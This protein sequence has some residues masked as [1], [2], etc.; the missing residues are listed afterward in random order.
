[1]ADFDA[2]VENSRKFPPG[3]VRS[4]KSYDNEIGRREKEVSKSTSKHI[5]KQSQAREP[6]QKLNYIS[7]GTYEP[8]ESNKAE[9][10]NVHDGVLD[11]EDGIDVLS[12]TMIEHSCIA[13]EIVKDIALKAPKH[14]EE[15]RFIASL[16]LIFYGGSWTN[17]AGII[18]AFEAFGTK[19]VL[20]EAYKVGKSFCFDDFDEDEVTPSQIKESFRKLGLQSALLIA[21]LVSP[22][23]AEICITVAFASK[24]TPLVPVEELLKQ[25]MLS[26]DAVAPEFDDYFSSIDT[27]WFDLIA[28][29]A[30]NILSLIL[31]G[32]FPRMTTAMYMGYLGVTL[33]MEGLGNRQINIPIVWESEIFDKSYWMKKST[34]YYA[35]G[36]VG[37]MAVWQAFTDYNGVC[38][39]LSWSMFLFPVVKVYN[40][41]ATNAGYEDVK[42]D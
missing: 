19:Q 40:L 10:E 11:F 16:G 33:F 26:P 25:S 36:I 8:T 3:D 41:L 28:V 29:I 13:F 32:C 15:F 17:L 1:M 42:T 18:A 20:E 5:F 9:V 35:W 22:S 37:V 39:I 34:Q 12:R 27:S 23:W 21:V 31:F 38:M 2:P 6:G 7:G 30:C 4:R 14:E 24:F